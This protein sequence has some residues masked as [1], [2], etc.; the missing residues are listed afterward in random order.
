MR[1]TDIKAVKYMHVVCQN[2]PV[3][4]KKYVL[5]PERQLRFIVPS[6]PGFPL[7][8]RDAR[9]PRVPASLMGGNSWDFYHHTDAF[10]LFLVNPD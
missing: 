3:K 8:R 1:S 10:F 6:S 7:R 5:P 9:F 4:L 2:V